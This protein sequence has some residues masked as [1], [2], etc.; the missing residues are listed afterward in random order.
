MPRLLSKKQKQQ[1]QLLSNFKF[2]DSDDDY[3]EDTLDIHVG[4]CRP[5]LIKVDVVDNDIDLTNDIK[6]R[7][8]VARL[9]ALKKYKEVWGI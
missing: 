1:L 6:I 5:E 3:Y 9:K 2:E 8:A 7:L 4:R